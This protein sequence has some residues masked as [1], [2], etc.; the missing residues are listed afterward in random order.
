MAQTA[1][2]DFQDRMLEEHVPPS[3]ILTH[4][5]YKELFTMIL[6]EEEEK[7]GSLIMMRI[8][9]LL[10]NDQQWIQ[11]EFENILSRSTAGVRGILDTL[12]R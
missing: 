6:K 3:S 10:F 2:R 11:D 9:C 1:G 5:K 12:Y 4:E 8:N 7:L